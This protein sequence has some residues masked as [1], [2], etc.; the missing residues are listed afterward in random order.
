MSLETNEK[1]LDA[2]QASMSR[3]QTLDTVMASLAAPASEE[4]DESKGEKSGDKSDDKPSGGDHKS[5]KKTS[6]ERI[7][8]LVLKNRETEA[9]AEDAVNR[10]QEL[11][12]K[13]KVL[14]AQAKPLEDTEKPRRNQFVSE[15]DYIESLTDWKA[16]KAVSKN[17]RRQ[18]EARLQA[19]QSDIVQQWDK[20]QE[21]V[22][23]SIPDYAE[24]LSASEV[25]IP[26]Y[27]HQ[28]LLESDSGPEIAYYLAL[29][30]E[31]AKRLAALK[32]LAAIRR[33]ISL[34]ADLTEQDE[35]VKPVK[36][37]S[38][39]PKQSKAPPPINPLRGIASANPGPAQSFD[40]YK[41]RRRAM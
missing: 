11:E 33:L 35:D 2:R 12:A 31:E 36:K 1:S 41:R 9:K 39:L 28:A 10:A 15:D 30:P 3:V 7:V 24:V 29:H 8:E 17:E 20:R 23:T 21:K 4:T 34:E 32:P 13:L 18:A 14:Q 16:E 19:E 26:P 25:V 5:S 6:Q 40:E 27:L 22:I 38:D 37:V